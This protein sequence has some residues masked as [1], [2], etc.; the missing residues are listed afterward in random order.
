M[1]KW[2]NSN[3]I[4]ILAN[5]QERK[6]ITFYYRQLKISSSSTSQAINELSK[7]GL[8]QKQRKGREMQIVLTEIGKV[9]QAQIW[10]LNRLLG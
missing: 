3:A 5:V 1:N 6:S 4:R 8:I 7:K 9:A 2:I 10:S